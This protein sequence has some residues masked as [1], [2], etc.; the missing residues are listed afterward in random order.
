MEYSL[1]GWQRPTPG[2]IISVQ[3]KLFG[4]LVPEW[5][6]TLHCEKGLIWQRICVALIKAK[7]RHNYCIAPSVWSIRK[8]MKLNTLTLKN[9]LSSGG[10]GIHETYR[11]TL[12]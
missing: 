4:E 12:L 5:V 2:V 6:A 11:K 10:D 8:V 7:G 3:P 1:L 9:I